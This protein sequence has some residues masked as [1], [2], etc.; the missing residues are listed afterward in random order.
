[1]T[2][3]NNTHNDLNIPVISIVAVISVLLTA[4]IIILI[5]VWYFNYAKAEFQ[6]KVVQQPHAEY[7]SLTADQMEI[8]N[9]YTIDKDK[10]VYKVP[11]DVAMDIIVRES[12]SSSNSTSSTR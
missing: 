11:I 9:G 3:V 2:D 10:G 12:V 4:L 8:L 7:E 6:R 5:Q 1:M